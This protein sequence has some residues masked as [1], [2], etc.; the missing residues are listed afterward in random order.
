MVYLNIRWNQNV[1]QE[2]FFEKFVIYIQAHINYIKKWQVFSFMELY[3][4]LQLVT[5]EVLFTSLSGYSFQQ[6]LCSKS[7]IYVKIRTITFMHSSQFLRSW[8]S[9]NTAL[10]WKLS[11]IIESVM[12][13]KPSQLT[14]VIIQW[15]RILKRSCEAEM[16]PSEKKWNFLQPGWKFKNS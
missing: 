9:I 6:I 15:K 5:R 14:Y 8:R 10:I 7:A 3:F 16:Y 2:L 4:F 1:I 12:F 13:H 11:H